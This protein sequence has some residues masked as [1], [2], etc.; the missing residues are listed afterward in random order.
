MP[1]ASTIYAVKGKYASIIETRIHTV[2]NR[3][4]GNGNMYS[5][6][7][8]YS[9]TAGGSVNAPMILSGRRCSG[10]PS[11]LFKFCSLVYILS[12]RVL[13][14][15]KLIRVPMACKSN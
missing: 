7:Q 6:H 15:T 5:A 10:I 1:H 11:P 4:T 14:M 13:E 9:I 8:P 2:A 12:S 3:N